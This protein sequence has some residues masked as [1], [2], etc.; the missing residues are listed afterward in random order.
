MYLRPNVMRSAD[1]SVGM[2]YDTPMFN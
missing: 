1:R 2:H